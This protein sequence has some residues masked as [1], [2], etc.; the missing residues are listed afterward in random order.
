MLHSGIFSGTVS[1]TH[2]SCLAP[3][4]SLALAGT[5]HATLWDALMHLQAHF[6][7]HTAKFVAVR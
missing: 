2:T 6:L 1:H 3:G 5:L 7:L 4:S